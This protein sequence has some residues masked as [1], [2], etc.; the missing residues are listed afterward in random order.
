MRLSA[1]RYGQ[2]INPALIYF[3]GCLQVI[4]GVTLSHN[5]LTEQVTNA[6][7]LG[8]L[9]RRMCIMIQALN[10][11]NKGPSFTSTLNNDKIWQTFHNIW[12]EYELHVSLCKKISYSRFLL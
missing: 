6:W 9:A 4:N 10:T 8:Y 5:L 7:K 12:L 2:R 11:I 1:N 3:N